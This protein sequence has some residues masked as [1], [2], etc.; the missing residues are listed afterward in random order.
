MLT[1]IQRML[2]HVRLIAIATRMN[3]PRFTAYL[4]WISTFIIKKKGSQNVLCIGRP[5]FD[6]DIRELSRSGGT[7]NYVV[8]PKTVFI[9][10]FRCFAPELVL[11]HVQYHE[12]HENDRAKRRCREFYEAFLKCF[13]SLTRSNAILTA[14]YNYSWQQELA[15]AARCLGIP[16]VVLFKEGIS[17]LFFEGMSP[18]TGYDKLVLQYT[19]NLFIGDRLIVYN[20]RIKQA[21]LNH[22]IRGIEPGI[23]EAVGIPRLDRYFRL[24]NMGSSIIFFS[25][26]FEDK[27]RHL[28]IESELVSKYFA[29]TREFHAEVLRFAVAHPEQRVIV[30]TKN[31]LKYLRY[32]QDI[33]TELSVSD[34]PNLTITN[35]GD[36]FELIKDA[37]AVIGYNSTT[38][39]EAFAARRIVMSADFRWGPIRDYFDEYPGLP[40]YVTTAQ[41][42]NDVLARISM[43]R[44]LDDP[45]LYSLLYQRIHVPDGNASAR[46]EAA[47]KRAILER[48][49]V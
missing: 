48:R 14:N 12:I 44:S 24:H 22:N 31:N 25:F 19:N 17:P 7:L 10:I 26:N 3:L 21:F 1:S 46:T 36:I 28:N 39:L 37:Y 20:E 42:I 41:D 32:V 38:L 40:N 45:Q 35:Q 47:I 4:V 27:F 13:I 49:T 11:K 18:Q 6:E 8:V 9:E 23:I 33:A 29:K 43:G 16:F 2:K 30:K 34:L 5:I 15:I